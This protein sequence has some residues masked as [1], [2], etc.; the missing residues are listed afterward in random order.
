MPEPEDEEIIVAIN[1]T[2]YGGWKAAEVTRSMDS[3]CG[4][5]S[6]EVFD[7]WESQSIPREIRPG[8]ACQVLLGDEPVITGYVDVVRPSISDE[9]HKITVSGRDRTCDLVDSSAEIES[10]EV[11]DQTLDALAVMLCEPFGIDVKVQTDVGNPFAKFAV[12]PGETVFACI[13]R[14]A[15]RRGVLCTTDGEG[16]LVLS[17]RGDFIAAGDAVVEGRNLLSGS[18]EYNHQDRFRD[19]KV[20]AQMPSFFDGASDPVHDQ[21]GVARDTNMMRHRPL[22]LTCESWADPADVEIRA[23]NECAYR[24]GE[25]SRVNI[26][27]AGWRQSGGS[28]WRPRLKLP[29]TSSSLY[30]ADNTEL[31]VRTVRYTFSDGDGRKA[32]LEMTRPDAYLKDCSGQVE[33]D[34]FDF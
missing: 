27:V 10:F 32:E 22:I 26:Q 25:S 19:Y 3:V 8:D 20:H 9:E 7:R 5:F 16:N 12:Q 6:V 28:L 34:P 14:A 13:E 30:I 31:V 29:V 11:F 23:K 18:A 21:I 15:K 24:A 1:G 17:A 33:D 2:N 4:G